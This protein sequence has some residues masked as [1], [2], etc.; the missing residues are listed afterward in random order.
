[1]TNV[2]AGVYWAWANDSVPEVGMRFAET[3]SALVARGAQVQIAF[4]ICGNGFAS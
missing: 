1:M 2:R 3:V 4:S